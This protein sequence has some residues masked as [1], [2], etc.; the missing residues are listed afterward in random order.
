MDAK[1][2]LNDF[3]EPPLPN[4]LYLSLL[5]HVKLLLLHG[6]VVAY[7]IRFSYFSLFTGVGVLRLT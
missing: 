6:Q 7:R 4:P 1:F 3:H 2:A 5:N